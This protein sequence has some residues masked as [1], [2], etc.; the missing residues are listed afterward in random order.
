MWVVF[1]SN[2]IEIGQMFVA[3]KQSTGKFRWALRIWKKTPK[4]SMLPWCQFEYPQMSQIFEI[5][6][7][8]NHLERQM[9]TLQL[10]SLDFL[11]ILFQ[12]MFEHG[13]HD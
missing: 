6:F 11:G 1:P 12:V 13:Y 7:G 3:E 8:I 10:H 5:F 2:L 4:T 9:F